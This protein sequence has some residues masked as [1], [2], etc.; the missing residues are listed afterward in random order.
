MGQAIIKNLKVK[1]GKNFNERAMI[2]E[3]DG[4]RAKKELLVKF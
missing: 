4:P 1:T 3:E 2:I